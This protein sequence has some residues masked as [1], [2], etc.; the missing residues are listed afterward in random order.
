[1]FE[2][3]LYFNSNALARTV[4]RIWTE[5]YKPLDLSPSHAFLLRAVL[6][7]PGLMPRELAKELSL[8]RSTVTRFLDSLVKRGFLIR[9]MTAQD[10]REIQIYPTKAAIEIHDE[11]D[12]TGKNLS[13]LMSSI[14][15]QDDLSQTVSNLRKIQNIVE[16]K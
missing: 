9:K 3:C 13:K 14:I 2:E 7:K 5:A 16:E 11:L 12:Q 4:T 6:S 10:G 8:S 1:M 15:G